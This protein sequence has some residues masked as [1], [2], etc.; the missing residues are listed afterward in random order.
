MNI[1]PKLLIRGGGQRRYKRNNATDRGHW[2]KIT[3]L[4]GWKRAQ[5]GVP[6]FGQANCTTRTEPGLR[7]HVVT[8]L[9]VA[10]KRLTMIL[11][12]F[13]GFGLQRSIPKCPPVRIQ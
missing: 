8:G 9:R 5:L 12:P 6:A 7:E 13:R 11:H 3:G 2:V 10:W 4:P 1:E